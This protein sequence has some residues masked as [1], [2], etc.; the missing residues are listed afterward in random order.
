MEQQFWLQFDGQVHGPYQRTDLL[1]L[2]ADGRIPPGALYSDT[3]RDFIP[4]GPSV[5]LPAAS[6][7]PTAP[8][9]V[10]PQLANSSASGTIGA[11]DST[12]VNPAMHGQPGQAQL[13]QSAAVQVDR[14]R[15]KSG[16]AVH[17]A[18]RFAGELRD[19]IRSGSTNR[20][21]DVVISYRRS[22]GAELARFIFDR[23]SQGGHRV[24]L[25]VDGLGAG[26]WEQALQTNIGNCTDFIPIITDGFF[27]RCKDPNDVVRKELL[28]AIQ[29]SRNIV[30]LL[31]AAHPF[32][33]DLPPELSRLPSYNGVPYSHNYSEECLNKLQQFLRSGN[34]GLE[35]LDSEAKLPKVVVVAAAVIFAVGLGATFQ[36]VL[37]L[38]GG[39]AAIAPYLVGL[40]TAVVKAPFA[41]LL[42][43]FLPVVGALFGASQVLRIRPSTLFCSRDWVVF[44][45]LFVVAMS[46]VCLIGGAI[47][48]IVQGLLL[49]TGS[50]TAMSL[51]PMTN[52]LTMLGATAVFLW[53]FFKRRWWRIVYDFLPAP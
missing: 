6:T 19:E 37:M 46:L 18:R 9:A 21:F 44:W 20:P 2:L 1:L 42:F 41:A 29:T 31:A 40:L 8:V 4:L 22:N 25:D 38:S 7:R 48:G 10:S 49:L 52:L 30:P 11:G 24:L 47:G 39:F 26:D 50:K 51:A 15:Q 35:R 28:C 13:A 32:P 17:S 5:T 12:Q 33:G 27:E 34:S 36:P 23:L 53:L 45:I 16:E 14:L 3:G 43:F